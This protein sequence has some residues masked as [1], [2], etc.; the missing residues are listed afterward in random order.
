MLSLEPGA[1]RRY[2]STYVKLLVR[3]ASQPAPANLGAARIGA[4]VQSPSH[5]RR[6]QENTT[7]KVFEHKSSKLP[8]SDDLTAGREAL[9]CT[10]RVS[11]HK[12][13][14]L[15]LT[16]IFHCRPLMLRPRTLHLKHFAPRTRIASDGLCNI[17]CCRHHPN[18]PVP[19]HRWAFS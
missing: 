5:L 1:E 9:A 3:L 7:A 11:T 15:N 8:H 12:C 6:Q 16:S 14:K 13:C 17:I 19:L 10:C 4:Q 18:H 2:D